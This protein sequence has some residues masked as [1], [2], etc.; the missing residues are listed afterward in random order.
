MEAKC[1]TD[2]Q[3]YR[4]KQ[5]KPYKAQRKGGTRHKKKAVDIVALAIKSTI[6]AQ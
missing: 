2:I 5:Q 4:K 6:N 1:K 3:I